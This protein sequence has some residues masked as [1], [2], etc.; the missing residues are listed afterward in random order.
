M[1]GQQRACA[2]ACATAFAVNIVLC[3]ILIPIFGAAGA[4]IATAAA[5]I[6]ET[7]SLF[8]VARHRLGFHVFIW[9]QRT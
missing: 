6:V 1:L 5:L 2:L 9:G 4:A 7:I 3:L 8:M